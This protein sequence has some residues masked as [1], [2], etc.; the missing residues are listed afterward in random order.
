MILKILQILG[1]QPWISNFF[2]LS[3][4]QFFLTV[5]Q[6][7]FCNKIPFP[8]PPISCRH[9]EGDDCID[10]KK[11][12]LKPCTAGESSCIFMNAK[13]T[14]FY[15]CLFIFLFSNFS[16]ICSKV[17]NQTI[18]SRSCFYEA[19][20]ARLQGCVQTEAGDSFSGEICYC[21]TDDCKYF[22]I[23]FI[24]GLWK[25]FQNLIIKRHGSRM[26]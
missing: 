7:N 11:G 12:E 15:S 16:T 26:L 18:I 17:N 1:L 6:S 10:G 9:C 22:E 14:K 4:E 5:G 20:G 8:A 2:S 21:N 3:L 25:F 19:N 24:L 13:G 23:N